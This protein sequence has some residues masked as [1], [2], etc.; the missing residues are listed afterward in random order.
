MLRVVDFRRADDKA[1][2]PVGRLG[3]EVN[4]ACLVCGGKRLIPAQALLHARIRYTLQTS[5]PRV[6]LGEELR[7]EKCQQLLGCNHVLS[8]ERLL[9]P[10]ALGVIRLVPGL[11]RRPGPC[12]PA[13]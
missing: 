8:P 12:G 11:A 1:V 3:G 6:L 5:E 2:Y 13:G 10:P 9:V 4:E 7:P